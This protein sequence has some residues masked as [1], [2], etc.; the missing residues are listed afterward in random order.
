VSGQT[1]V[2]RARKRNPIVIWNKILHGH[3]NIII[4]IAIAAIAERRMMYTI[5]LQLVKLS[6]YWDTIELLLGGTPSQ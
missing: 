5:T 4:I 1:R 2:I 3:A 6:I